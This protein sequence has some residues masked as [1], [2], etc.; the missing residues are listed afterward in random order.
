M[1][2]R[3]L[4]F[5]LALVLIVAHI[6]LLVGSG[7][8]AEPSVRL[9][10]N[11]NKTD[12]DLGSDPIALTAKAT[13]SNLTYAWEVK[14]PG[15]I[16]GEGSAVFYVLPNKIKGKS[17]QALVT[18]T[19]TD[20]AGQETTETVT[21]NILAKT[22]SST[23]A[24]QGMSRNT[25]IAIGVGGAA[26]LGGGIAAL[27]GGGDDDDDDDDTFNGTFQRESS[28][29]SNYGG[30]VYWT[31]IYRLTQ[32]GN[33]VTGT[34]ELIGAYANCCTANFTVAA[35]GTIDGDFLILAEE[36]GAAECQGTDGCLRRISS[37]SGTYNFTLAENG[38]ILRSGSVDY[39]RQSMMKPSFDEK[40]DTV[41]RSANCDFIRK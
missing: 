33:S 4:K 11:P 10:V 37:D 39:A 9:I 14:G 20:A 23:P 6:T 36:A 12:V 29:Q 41:S 32:E 40:Q 24:K 22:T 31:E 25:K 5:S 3:G 18:V 34:F 30:F 19:I 26:L 28:A 21:F 17:E 13:G 15:K 8:A 27:A 1:V 2:R 7:Y 35:Y 38:Q 16:D